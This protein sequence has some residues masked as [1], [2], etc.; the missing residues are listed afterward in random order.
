M[1][2]TLKRKIKGKWNGIMAVEL[3]R[4]TGK[5]GMEADSGRV[6]ERKV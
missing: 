5:A 1:Y 2:L 3:H 4:I 6:G